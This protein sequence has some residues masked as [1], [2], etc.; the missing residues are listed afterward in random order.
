MK[1]PERTSNIPNLPLIS[2]P[3]NFHASLPFL[4]TKDEAALFEVTLL[5]FLSVVCPCP[6]VHMSCQVFRNVN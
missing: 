4:A 2:L 6:N 1:Q 3:F 5:S